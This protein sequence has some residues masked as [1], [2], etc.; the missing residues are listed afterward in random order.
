MRRTRIR[1]W[2]GRCKRCGL[3][4]STHP[5]QVSRAGGAAG[6]QIGSNALALIA[7]LNKRCG[8]SMRKTCDILQTHFGL[9]LSPGGLSQALDRIRDRLQFAYDQLIKAL[10]ASPAVYADETGW[11]KGGASAWLWTFANSLMTLYTIDNRSAAVVRRILGDDYMGVLVSDCLASYNPH[12]GLKSKCFAHHLKAL[13]EA[14]NKA[15]DSVFLQDMHRLLLVVIALHKRRDDFTKKRYQQYVDL[16]EAEMTDLLTPEYQHPAEE[17][18]A[19]RLRRQR[20]HLLTCLK[21]PGV[22]PTNNLAERQL[23]PAV[24]ARKLSA[25]NKTDSGAR[26]FAVLASL[27]E[28]CH[29]QG[30]SFAELVASA[31]IL[32]QRPPPTL[33]PEPAADPS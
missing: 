28:T 26:T 22:D 3:V 30:R 10:R 9:S 17:Y 23:R 29:Q 11:W 27:A 7:D 8:L 32:T 15:P 4:R 20:E 18:L 19:N 13:S 21:M 1:T 6:V 14:R 25:G 12:P 5:Q 2:R 16:L 31:M 24:I 33:F